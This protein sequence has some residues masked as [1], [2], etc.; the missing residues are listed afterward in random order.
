MT[1]VY[2][3]SASSITGRTNYGSML[4]G[5]TAYELPGDFES[6]A[7][8]SVG[9]GGAANVEFTSIPATFT[10][11][12]IRCIVQSNRGG[13]VGG[14]DLVI[15]FNADTTYTNY[16]Y[17][18]RL[19]GDGSSAT[20]DNFNSSPQSRGAGWMSANQ[21]TNILSGNVIDILDYKNTN[22]NKT[23]RALSGADY[24]GTGYIVLSSGCWYNTNAI[25]SILLKPAIGTLINQYSQ[26][27][28]YG[29]RSA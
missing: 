5:N 4:A 8:V 18:H 7:T 3:L 26:F 14:D 11:L 16:G 12:Q 21:H 10:H 22:K 20:A 2:K 17:T 19:Y 6:I 28:L 23:I 24:N 29:I 25:T 9:S 27:A 15:Q 13:G 1:P